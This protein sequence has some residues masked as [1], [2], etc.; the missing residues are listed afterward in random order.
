MHRKCLWPSQVLESSL[1]PK[2]I[3]LRK[4]K[5]MIGSGV[6]EE[7]RT[8]GEEEGVGV[9]ERRDEMLP[10]NRYALQ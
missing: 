7:G 6:G 4:R 10:N 2:I 5:V 1:L 8:G 3:C 9:G